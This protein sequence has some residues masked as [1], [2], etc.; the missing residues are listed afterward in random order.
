[1]LFRSPQSMQSYQAAQAQLAQ[2]LANSGGVGANQA[3]LQ[4]EALRQNLLNNQYT[5][6]MSTLQTGDQYAQAATN[7]ALQSSG[8]SDQYALAAIQQ[9]LASNQQ[10]AQ[11]S[12][13]YFNGIAQLFG[14]F[15]TTRP[16]TTTT[17]ATQ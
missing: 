4:L 11:L 7:A 17:G 8:L 14:G 6:G 2:Q 1:M 13:Q 5:Q 12:Q 16:A 15:G 9:G 10:A 3:S